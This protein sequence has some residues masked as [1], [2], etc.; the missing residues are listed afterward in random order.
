MLFPALQ[1]QKKIAMLEPVGNASAIQKRIFRAS[2]A[3][4]ITNSRNYEALTR[5]DI[6]QIMNEFNFQDAGMVSDD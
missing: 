2:L 6:D 5:T 4:A 1:A 3:E